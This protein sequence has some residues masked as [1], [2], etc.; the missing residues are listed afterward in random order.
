MDRS[1][2][3]A[4]KQLFIDLYAAVPFRSTLFGY[5]GGLVDLSTLWNGA[6]GVSG[7]ILPNVAQSYYYLGAFFAPLLS[8]LIIKLNFT[9]FNKANV[10][11]NPYMYSVLMYMT[12]YTATTVPM[13]NFSIFCK[14]LT[15][16][17][18][19]ML[20]FACFSNERFEKIMEGDLLTNAMSSTEGEC[21][22]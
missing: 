7:Q 15:T 17:I 2:A 6:N 18:A 11:R 9:C 20:L 12:I 22:Q 5:S 14:A 16:R 19:F 13:Y 1:F 3:D 8:V 4:I 21:N 10:T